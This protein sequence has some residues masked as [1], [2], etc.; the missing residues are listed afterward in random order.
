MHANSCSVTVLVGM[1]LMSLAAVRSVSAAA[2]AD[3]CTLLSA[4]EVSAVLGATVGA[5][6]HPNSASTSSC[7]WSAGATSVAVTLTT[8]DTYNS[9]KM[10]LERTQQAMAAK[11][12]ANAA[13]VSITPV[14]GLGDEAYYGGI[15]AHAKLNVR[16]GSSSV[17]V[18]ILGDVPPEFCRMNS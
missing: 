12:N 15:G 5:G 8:A 17:S 10:I 13:Q 3:A 9:S 1:S 16:K 7:L 18:E 4:A 2:P 14:S 6:T 11:K